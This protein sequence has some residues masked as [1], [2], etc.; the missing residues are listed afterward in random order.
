M[1][2]IDAVRRAKA[3][4]VSAGA[5]LSGPCGALRITRRAAELLGQGA[6]LLFKDTGNQCEERAVDIVCYPDGQIY[7]CLVDAGGA[8]EPSWQDKGV[9]EAARYR[10]VDAPPVLPPWTPAY[11][12]DAV[13]QRIGE[14]LWTDY[15]AAGQDPNPGM[16]IWAWRCAW[17]IAQGLNVEQAIIKHQAEWRTVLEL[18]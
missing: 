4:L 9:A 12:G 11:P 10:S 13:G 1:T 18:A 6:G 7:D 2:G 14:V 8:N 16:M 15:L 5:D 17:D 3:Q